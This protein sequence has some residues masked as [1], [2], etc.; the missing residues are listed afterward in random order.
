MIILKF[1]NN[2]IKIFS[3]FYKVVYFH[4]LDLFC[5]LSCERWYSLKIQ[6]RL[7]YVSFSDSM[8][9]YLVNEKG[10]LM[11]SGIKISFYLCPGDQS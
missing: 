5:F 9:I 7:K 1:S 4:S 3:F 11:C 6:L 10:C 2:G 8:M